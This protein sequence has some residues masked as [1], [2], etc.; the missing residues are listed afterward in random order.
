MKRYLTAKEAASALDISLPTLYAY[1]SRGLIRSEATAGSKR[2]RRYYAEDVDKLI[3]RKEATR[4]PEKAA[5][6]ALDWGAPVL[7]SA[8][9]LIIKGRLY[10]RGQ[11]VMHLARTATAEQVAGLLWADDLTAPLMFDV[12]PDM[13]DIA[14]DQP[15]LTRILATLPL[16]GARDL[17]SYDLRPEAVMTTGGRILNLMTTFITGESSGGMA[18]R[19]AAHYAP[20]A[21]SLFDAALIVCADHELNASS[22]TARVA[23]SA[24]ATPYN[25]VMSGLATLQG[26][27]HGG[28]TERVEAFLR[29]L[30]VAES[31]S[32][33]VADRLRRGEPIPGFG[34]RLYPD[35]DP[36]AALLLGLLRDYDTTFTD[37][38]IDAVGALIG[39]S[40][41]VDFAL[42]ALAWTLDLPTGTPLVLFALGRTIGWIGHAIE[43]YS[44]DTLIRPRAR[45]TGQQPGG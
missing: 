18:A 19:L 43:Q 7:E 39:E 14:T 13:P 37:A 36:R 34:H 38:V 42:V 3:Q 22:F 12:P 27:K 6:S 26:M 29:E 35:G 16:V 45:Y 8:L 9:T 23:A 5:E 10:Y 11:D 28:S 31:V 15:V 44:T 32:A 24:G 17:A 41:N 4:N 40:P 2:S 30:A 21:E 20:D 33:G 1:V 25:V